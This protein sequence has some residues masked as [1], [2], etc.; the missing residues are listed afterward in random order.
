VLN[1]SKNILAIFGLFVSIYATIMIEFWKRKQNHIHFVLGRP[2]TED[3]ETVMNPD[4]LGYKKMS[5]SKFDV[6]KSEKN[7]RRCKS[8]TA[9]I[10]LFIVAI[11]L[12]SASVAGYVVVRNRITNG[13]VQGVLTAIILA[14]TSFIHNRCVELLLK[15]ANM[16]YLNDKNRAY[17]VNKMAFEF[18]NLNLP[19]VYALTTNDKRR[20]N[21]ENGFVYDQT[22]HLIFGIV[23]STCISIFAGEYLVMFLKYQAFK[24]IY[25]I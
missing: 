6:T 11:I 9:K 13:T 17:I 19:I 15:Q 16:K 8:W 21:I 20:Q 2:I 22:Y 24:I 18:I 4:Y 5:W 25:F 7:S 14:V 12:L 23:F 10:F 1:Q 3:E